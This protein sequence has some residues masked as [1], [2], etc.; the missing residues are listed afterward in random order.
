MCHSCASNKE[1][2]GHNP[3]ANAETIRMQVT[4]SLSVIAD[5][6]KKT[7]V[8]PDSFPPKSCKECAVRGLFSSPPGAAVALANH[9]LACATHYIDYIE[10][11]VTKPGASHGIESLVGTRTSPRC[12]NTVRAHGKVAPA[13]SVPF[14]QSS[15]SKFL[16]IRHLHRE[17]VDCVMPCGLFRCH[18]AT[19][20]GPGRSVNMLSSADYS[21][22]TRNLLATL[23]LWQVS[24]FR[25]FSCH[26]EVESR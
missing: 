21:V 1:T 25:L 15:R 6:G 18:T 8:G 3:S 23:T 13:T 9:R 7:G 11:I 20:C 24:P 5:V 19:L 26:T 16:S 10:L 17:V 4:W 2:A 14:V 22:V 12:G